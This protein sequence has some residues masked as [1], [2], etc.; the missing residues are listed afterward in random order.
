MRPYS[1]IRDYGFKVK[2][3]PFY[4]LNAG[5]G[6]GKWNLSVFVQNIFSSRYHLE[7][8]YVNSPWF[9]M[10]NTPLGY[11]GH[12]MVS[13]QGVYTF[14]Y[15]KQVYQDN[16]RVPEKYPPIGWK[17]RRIRPIFQRDSMQCGVASLAMVCRYCGAQAEHSEACR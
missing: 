1:Y 8:Y 2:R 17:H 9:S 6:N 3:I 11:Q 5:W 16:E 10:H 14:G 13:I 12:R 15:G 7:D 4:N